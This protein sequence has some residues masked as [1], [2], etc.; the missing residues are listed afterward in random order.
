V[1]VQQTTIEEAPTTSRLATPASNECSSSALP[2]LKQCLVEQQSQLADA[3]ERVAELSARIA[4]L[5]DAL[6][7][8]TDE[9]ARL[10]RRAKHKKKKTQRREQE[11]AAAQ[12]RK[13]ARTHARQW[14]ACRKI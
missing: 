10:E 13:C 7:D 12:V 14:A 11:S 5:E 3:G 6:R 4:Q 8:K 1:T 9:C 2:Q